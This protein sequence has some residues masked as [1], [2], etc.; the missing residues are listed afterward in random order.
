MMPAHYVP[1]RALEKSALARRRAMPC[2]F[3]RV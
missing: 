1:L 3:S 2:L